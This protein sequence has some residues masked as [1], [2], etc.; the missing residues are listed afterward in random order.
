MPK[1]LTDPTTTALP[2]KARADPPESPDAAPAGASGEPVAGGAMPEGKAMPAPPGAAGEN[3]FG[4][5]SQHFS[6]AGKRRNTAGLVRGDEAMKAAKAAKLERRASKSA[7][8]E[9]LTQ[10]AYDSTSDAYSVQAVR[11][12]FEELGYSGGDGCTRPCCAGP[13]KQPSTVMAW[14]SSVEADTRQYNMTNAAKRG[15]CGECGGSLFADPPALA[16]HTKKE[17]Q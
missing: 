10:I 12:L 13:V 7:L 1:D 14:L 17:P 2:D 5:P 11:A 16:C 15:L 4:P 6:A 8:I 9:R 3:A